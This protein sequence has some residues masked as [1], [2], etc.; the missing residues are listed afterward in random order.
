MKTTLYLKHWMSCLPDQSI[1][2]DIDHE[3]R[4]VRLSM[5]AFD[6]AL[7]IDV[8]MR[9]LPAEHQV[10]AYRDDARKDAA[11]RTEAAPYRVRIDIASVRYRAQVVHLSGHS[12]VTVAVTLEPVLR[13]EPERGRERRAIK[14]MT[15]DERPQGLNDGPPTAAIA[16][17]VAAH[18]GI[19]QAFWYRSHLLVVGRCMTSE[20]RVLERTLGEILGHAVDVVLYEPDEWANLQETHP[21]WAA[22]VSD[23]AQVVRVFP[24]A[25]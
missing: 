16:E 5:D 2:L 25:V 13:E 12:D 7:V 8:V 14:D 10:L 18:E 1:D 20:L 6:S 17:H 19:E 9:I 3:A 4:E 22:I 15:E 23:A 11:W 24:R 21:A